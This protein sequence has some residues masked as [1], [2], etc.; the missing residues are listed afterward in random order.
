MQFGQFVEEFAEEIGLSK[1]E[2]DRAVRLVFESIEA[3]LMEGEEVSV[4]GFGKFSIKER[5]A[6]VGHNPQTGE[7]IKIKAKT[8]AAFKPSSKLTEN[9]N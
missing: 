5:A 3:A 4:P 9:L 1:L 7:K 2:A 6:R 8:V